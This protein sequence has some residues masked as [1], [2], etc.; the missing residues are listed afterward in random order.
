MLFAY[1]CCSASYQC[2]VLRPYGTMRCVL[3]CIMYA[4]VGSGLQ[5]ADGLRRRKHP[6][7]LST[8]AVHRNPLGRVR[9]VQH[10]PPAVKVRTWPPA[11]RRRPRYVVST[12]GGAGQ[13]GLKSEYQLGG[14]QCSCLRR[15]L[16]Q[17]IF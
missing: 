13:A 17:C 12:G 10:V 5:C 2:Q 11:Y 3:Y 1:I 4:D 14:S 16:A 7:A 15:Q 8:S 6:V 9:L